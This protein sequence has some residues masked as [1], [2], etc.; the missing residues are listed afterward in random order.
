MVINW[1]GNLSFGRSAIVYAAQVNGTIAS[2]DI[3]G[4][5]SFKE[6]KDVVLGLLQNRVSSRNDFSRSQI[7]RHVTPVLHKKPSEV[8]TTSGGSVERMEDTGVKLR[9]KPPRFLKPRRFQP[10]LTKMPLTQPSQ[11]YRPCWDHHNNSWKSHSCY[12]HQ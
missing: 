3:V 4:R 9:K 1:P 10:I 7:G 6:G 8:S 2:G 12:S 11:Q 5:R